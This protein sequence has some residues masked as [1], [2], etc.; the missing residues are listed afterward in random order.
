[1]KRTILTLA[2]FS[3]AITACSAAGAGPSI[4]ANDGPVQ[5]MT[6]LVV[7]TLKLRDTAEA[8]T[9]EQAAE[10]L[11]LWEVYQEVSRSD[12]TAS[13][14]IDGLTA[15]IKETM[16][17]SQIK[18]ISAMQLT[19]EDVMAVMRAQMPITE[20]SGREGNA[21][22]GG[23]P[24][25]GMPGGGFPGEGMPPGGGMPGGGE[26]MPGGEFGGG[27]QAVGTARPEAQ[28]FASRRAAGVSPLLLN[29]LLE[30]LKETAGS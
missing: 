9:K 28:Q 12:M 29:T 23:F 17:D 6:E 20:S 13:A 5:P 10:L 3:F 16:T 11:P 24:G 22:G 26:M 4:G 14:E 19:Q 2:I 8:V 25:G 30:Y 27:T 7:G 15:Q 18:S 1:M 21:Q